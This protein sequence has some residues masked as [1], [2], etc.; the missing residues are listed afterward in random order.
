M[1]FCEKEAWETY[2]G[3]SRIVFARLWVYHMTKETTI[4]ETRG[5][6][7]ISNRHILCFIFEPIEVQTCSVP[8]NDRLNLI[9]VKDSYVDDG[10]LARNGRE[11]AIYH[12][13]SSQ[14]KKNIFAF[15]IITFEPIKVQTFSA[16]Q[17]DRLNLR[18][19]KEI[20][21]DGEKLARNGRKTA[22]CQSQI[23]VISL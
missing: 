4:E 5:S 15:C 16:P 1:F 21:E 3:K 23:F 7:S 8:Q 13:V 20:Y 10:K 14:V 12:F 9:I 6:P 17:N 22:I 2:N 19:V 11:T 18:F